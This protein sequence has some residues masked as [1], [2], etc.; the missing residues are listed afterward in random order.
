MQ[1]IK[2]Y[3]GSNLNTMKHPRLLK[4]ESTNSNPEANFDMLTSQKFMNNQQD[5]MTNTVNFIER[6][7]NGNSTYTS[8]KRQ[9]F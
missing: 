5:D 7:T 4:K 9:I 1:D 8:I 2:F 3:R 6:G